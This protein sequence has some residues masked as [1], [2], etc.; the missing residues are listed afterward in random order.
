MNGKER[1]KDANADVPLRISAG[2]EYLK[3]EHYQ[4]HRALLHTFHSPNS[5]ELQGGR[6]ASWLC[7]LGSPDRN[8][9]RQLN[10]VVD[11]HSGQAN[12]HSTG[13]AAKLPRTA[14]C[15]LHKNTAPYHEKDLMS[16]KAMLSCRTSQ[17]NSCCAK[18]SSSKFT[19]RH[20]LSKLIPL[21]HNA[22][23]TLKSLLQ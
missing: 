2:R 21:S 19:P 8:T 13:P 18:S 10:H 3:R 12:T 7:H 17:F 22:G 15:S 23:T 6:K 9:D 14:F 16:N 20:S 4:V 11:L 1:E 5:Y